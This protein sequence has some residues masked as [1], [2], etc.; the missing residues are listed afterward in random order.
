MRGEDINIDD[1]SG[2]DIDHQMMDVD[3]ERGTTG[4]DTSDPR[5]V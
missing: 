2:R 4:M 3:S 1:G 5:R